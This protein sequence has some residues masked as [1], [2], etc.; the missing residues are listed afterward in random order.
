M[1]R[2]A[3]EVFNALMKCGWIDRQTDTDIWVYAQD[4]DVLELLEDY[5]EVLNFDLYR[6]GDR[7]YLIPTQDNELFLKNNVDFRK[8]IKDTSVRTRDLYLF[9]YL[10][11][12]VIYIFFSG[13]GSDPLCRDFISKEKLVEEFTEHCQI[14]EKNDIKVE[15]NQADFSDNFYQLSKV[16]LSKINGEYNSQKIDSKYGVVNRIMNKYKIDG[17]FEVIDDIQIKPTRKLKDLMPYFLMKK[18]IVEIQNWLKEEESNATVKQ[19]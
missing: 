4:T 14:V 15:A 19:G 5:K 2:K 3:I 10:S 16:W 1:N 7:L 17:L 11:I 12:Y 8:D 13:E 6:S 9:N 18:H